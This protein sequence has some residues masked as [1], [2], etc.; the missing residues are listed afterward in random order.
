MALFL[1]VLILSPLKHISSLVN[2]KDLINFTK[3]LLI[4][5][6]TEAF[7]DHLLRCIG[8]RHISLAYVVRDSETVAGLCLPLKADQPYSKKHGSIDDNLIACT[9]YANGL[10]RNNNADVYFKL[11]EVT[12]GTPFYNLIKPFTRKKD[13]RAIFFALV[14]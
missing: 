4:I 7:C 9:S 2:G 13:G 8:S 3:T 5:K 1:K 11:E 10:Y 14:S 6:W 12:C